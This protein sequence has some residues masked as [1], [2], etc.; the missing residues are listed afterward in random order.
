M[1]AINY[2]GKT[3]NLDDEGYLANQDEWSEDVA[4]GIATHEGLKQLTP[5]QLEIIKFMRGYYKKFSAFPILNYVCKNVR[6]SRECVNEQFINPDHAWKIAGLPKLD[7]IHF[8]TMDGKNYI[9]EE[10]C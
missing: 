6:Q 3:I 7:N 9:M 8:V 4:Q 1:T 10:C 5:E 2:A